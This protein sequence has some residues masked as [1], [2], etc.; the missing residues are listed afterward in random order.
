MRLS[1]TWRLAYLISRLFLRGLLVALA[2]AGVQPATAADSNSDRLRNR[3]EAAYTTDSMEV[4][5]ERVH[6]H[7]T[8]QRAYSERGFEPFW[9]TPRGLTS[10]GQALAAWLE[11]GPRRHGLRP[12]DY[13]LDA[14]R[15]LAAGSDPGSQIDLELALSDAFVMLGSHL[16][17][18]RLNPESLD[19]EWRA[20]RR[21][22]DL[23]PIITRAAA[24]TNPVAEL[25]ALL[26][27]ADAYRLLVTHLERLRSLAAAGGWNSVGADVTLRE[28]DVSPRVAELA[29][30]LAMTDGY[31]ETP[32]DIFTPTLAEA[33]RAFQRRHGL[34]ADGVV[35][36][37]TLA[38]LNVPIKER[39]DQI[40]VNLERWRWLPETLG[41][42][43]I[44]VNIA[45]FTMDVVEHGEKKL[46]MRVVVG[47]PYRRTPVFSGTMTYL[48]FNPWWEVPQSIAS[49]DKLPEIRKDPTYLQRQG[50]TLLSGWGSDE[51]VLDPATID[52]Q[53]VTP[54]TFRYRL[55]QSPGPQNA[56]GQ[57]KFM[58]PNPFAVYLHDTPSRELFSKEAR[59]FSSGCIRLE[60][61]LELAD[62]LLSEAAPW[63]SERIR[64][65]VA[66][67]KETTVRLPRGLPVHLLYWTAWI[68][69]DGT[70][71]FRD[72]VYGRDAPVLRELRERPP[73]PEPE[74]VF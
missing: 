57:V 26:P 65:T 67:G 21:H 3:I 7:R 37:A 33:V 50:Y 44:L 52:W 6:A 51:S 13:H 49:K 56:L 61:P 60:R 42:R 12:T 48:V 73:E 32:Q 54:A 69:D 27:Q 29:Q 17:A 2:A 23:V 62:L 53:R 39:I 72:D 18:G 41:E 24:G 25:E 66:S 64:Q 74:L 11:V 4:A 8:L 71:Q 63:T 30:R 10:A 5:D 19:P 46:S 31:A 1:R 55:R 16:V 45:A 70:L 43:Y 40:V 22:A 28:G 20:N 14:V 9:I 47:R 15:A 58:F 68:D 34:N 35:G 59:T 38:A 36:K